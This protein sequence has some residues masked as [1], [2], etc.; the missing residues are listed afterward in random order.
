[1]VGWGGDKTTLRFLVGLAPAFLGISIFA[2]L[3]WRIDVFMLS[4][5]RPVQ[6]V[7]YYGSAYRILE[8][9]MIL[10]QSL[11]VSLYPQMAT[12][13]RADLRKLRIIG[14]TALRYLIALSL[15][16]AVCASLLATPGLLMLYGKGFD[17]ASTTLSV[18]IF[19]LIPYGVVRY[20]AYLLVAAN[21]QRVDLTLNIIMSVINV[22][23]NLVLIPRYAHLGAALSTLIAICVY[24][25]LQYWYLY[26]FLPGYAGT[27]SLQPSVVI[28]TALTG[29]YV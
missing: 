13:V 1:M 29:L 20:H 12:A 27:I 10:P 16:T 21:K 26:R 6:D 23:L 25:A 8:L 5:M 2:T 22:L 24:A 28:V 18:L 14:N 11:C 4:Q 7:G 9:A 17:A 19:T 3:Y 15:P